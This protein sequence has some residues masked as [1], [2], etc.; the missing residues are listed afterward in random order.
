MRRL[1]QTSS[2]VCPSV[3]VKHRQKKP[4]GD[5]AGAQGGEGIFGDES[6]L[7]AL[8]AAASSKNDDGEVEDPIRLV[9]G[10]WSL[11]NRKWSLASIRPAGE[12]GRD[13]RKGRR[14]A[15][16]WQRLFTW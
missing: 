16:L 7:D 13:R 1:L 6:Q 9:K 4:I 12:Q 8:Q 11:R 3:L 15:I 10:R 14:R 2:S 5:V